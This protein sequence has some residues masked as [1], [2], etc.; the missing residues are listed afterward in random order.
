MGGLGAVDT[1]GRLVQGTCG[2]GSPHQHLSVYPASCRSAED[3]LEVFSRHFGCVE[4]DSTCYAIPAAATVAKW[5]AR[6][7]SAFRFLVKSFGAFCASTVELGSLPRSTRHLLGPTLDGSDTSRRVSYA[8]MPEEAKQ[9]LWASFHAALEPIIAAGKLGCVVFQFHLTFPLS[10]QSKD[11][12]EDL[13]RRLR[14]DARMAVEF[15]NRDWVVGTAGDAT[16][17]W[18]RRNGLALVAADELHHE[19][20]QPDR[21]QRGLPS[22]EVR[23]VM[24]TRLEATAEWGALVRVHR[25][26]GAE[27]RILHPYEIAAWGRRVATVA[28]GLR[29]PVW[30]AWGTDWRDAPLMNARALDAE[31]GAGVALDWASA[32]RAVARSAGVVALFAKA[33]GGKEKEEEEEEEEEARRHTQPYGSHGGGD[34]EA[35]GGSNDG[36]GPEAGI[37]SASSA[38]RGRAAWDEGRAGGRGLANKR[39]ASQPTPG[40]GPAAKKS[41]TIARMF[42]AASQKNPP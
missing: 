39:R 9:D 30:V 17:A 26:H 2:W 11:H 12:V 36:G 8:S 33:V 25:R 14:A 6:T 23:R 22:G 16:A 35:N 18:C 5:V 21:A 37:L 15:R 34:E 38:G 3:R 7:P 1:T 40:R 41:S 31:V 28:P 42:A 27:E 32:Q 24:P 10:Q 13:R 4:V 20:M 19:T 29:G